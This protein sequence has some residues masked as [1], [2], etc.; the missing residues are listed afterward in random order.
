MRPSLRSL[1]RLAALPGPLGRCLARTVRQG[2][3]FSGR[4]GDGGMGRWGGLTV[5]HCPPEAD[6]L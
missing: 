1:P 2:G 6:A 3:L 4:G 5:S